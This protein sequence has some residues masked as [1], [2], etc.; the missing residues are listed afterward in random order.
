MGF[1][2]KKEI[3]LVKGFSDDFIIMPIW[4]FWAVFLLYKKSLFLNFLQSIYQITGQNMQL[5]FKH[6]KNKLS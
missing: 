2:R 3:N 1:K 4:T 6:I 5:F